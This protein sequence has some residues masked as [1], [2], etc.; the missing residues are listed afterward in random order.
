MEHIPYYGDNLDLLY[1]SR[2][3]TKPQQGLTQDLTL[4]REMR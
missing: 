2:T 3:Q 1:K 4:T